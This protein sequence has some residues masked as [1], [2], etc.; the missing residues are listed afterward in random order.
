MVQAYFLVFQMKLLKSER[1]ER[2]R[3]SRLCHRQ[4]ED[5][6]YGCQSNQYRLL[7]GD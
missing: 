4:P 1:L 2:L 6:Y 5:Y 3:Q 7:L